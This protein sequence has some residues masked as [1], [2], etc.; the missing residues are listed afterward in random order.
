MRK[1]YILLIAGAVFAGMLASCATTYTGPSSYVGY[2]TQQGQVVS[3]SQTSK[4]FGYGEL[5]TTYED[6]F[7]FDDD[8]NLLK[9]KQIEYFNTTTSDN[10][11]V[12]WETEY[13]V[14]GDYVLPYRSS[15]NDTVYQEVEYE[16]LQTDATGEVTQPTR[17]RSFI[18]NRYRNGMYGAT[19]PFTWG[20]DLSN[21][22]V[23]FSSDGLFVEK[24]WSYDYYNGYYSRKTLTLGQDNIVLTHYSSSNEK[25]MEGLK[26]SYTGMVPATVKQ[27]ASALKGSNYSFDYEWEV[28]NGKICQTNVTFHQ[29]HGSLEIYF[30]AD[31]EYNEAGLPL[32]ETWKAA[33]SP[34]AEKDEPEV[35]FQNS[36]VY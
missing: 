4:V 16:L 27:K 12:V 24:E 29:T 9:H 31:I 28:I 30:L 10:K 8:G 14:V 35:I 23:D 6:E 15:I 36:F 20:I 19:Y 32:S 2:S 26:K 18:E 33:H 13:K 3:A 21:Y 1:G 17:Y 11:Y 5:Q 7:V 25:L 22:S 34:D